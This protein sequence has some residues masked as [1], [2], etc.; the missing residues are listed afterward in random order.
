MM[1]RITC[2]KKAGFTLVELMVSIVIV[3]VLAALAFALAKKGISRANSM[4]D[5]ATMRQLYQT[6][7][8]YAADNNGFLPGPLY[9]GVK[10]VYRPSARGRLANYIAPYLGYDD[11]SVDEFLPAMGYSWQKTE[12]SRNANCCYIRKDVPIRGDEDDLTRPFGHLPSGGEPQKMSA[13]FS[14]ID[15]ARAW[16]IS[17]LDQKHP[18]LGN[19]SWKNEVPAEMSH[20]TYRLAI[21]YDGHAGKL[22]ED[23][24]PL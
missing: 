21:Y 6:F 19:P 14:K 7:P 9:T 17:D 10:A 16:M 15:V 3:A 18:D 12:A 13:V 24:N 11:P 4:K 20:G 8:L 22:D 2:R 5:M 23:N 1:N